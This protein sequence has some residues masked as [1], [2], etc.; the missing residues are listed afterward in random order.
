MEPSLLL[1]LLSFENVFDCVP[2]EYLIPLCLIV[3]TDRETEEPGIISGFVL[4]KPE[5]L[6]TFVARSLLVNTHMNII[7]NLFSPASGAI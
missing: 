5:T 3:L 2:P 1:S 4:G 7:S 6:A